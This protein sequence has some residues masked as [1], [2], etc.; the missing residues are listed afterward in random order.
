[1]CPSGRDPT[2]EGEDCRP[3]FE[4]KECPSK[5]LAPDLIQ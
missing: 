4:L 1:M 2:V 5:S 3:G